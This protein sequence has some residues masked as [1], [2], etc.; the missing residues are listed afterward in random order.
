[1][2]KPP[3]SNIGSDAAALDVALGNVPDSFRRR[4]VDAYLDLKHRGRVGDPKGAASSHSHF[5]EAVLRFLQAALTGT[6]IAFGVHI[7]NFQQEC[8]K[9]ENAPATPTN[10]A[11]R[12]IIP[13][14]LAFLQTLRNKRGT[15]H[16]AGDVDA[17]TID[18]ATIVRVADWIV[19][20]LLR[21]YH[22]L[23][24]E[25]AQSLLNRMAT[26]QIPD[27]W[28]FG[29]TK[30]VL[31][32]ELKAKDRAMLLLYGETSPVAIEVLH[33][34][35]EYSTLSNFRKD[36]TRPLHLA[37]LIEV[38]PETEMLILTPT[39]EEHVECKLLTSS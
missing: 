4:I 31:R 9:L 12:L 38:D 28:T 11:Q 18:L 22:K 8:V 33:Q 2:P 6:H 39:G 34:W 29:E 20:E 25:E 35:M 5:C 14:A 7:K 15:G 3:S 23:S 30:R 21:L 37:R 26:R 10:E 36:V 13:R 17:N 24:M 19:C 32:V 16:A 1:M 27:V